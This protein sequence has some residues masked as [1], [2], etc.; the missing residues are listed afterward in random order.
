MY[1][2]GETVKYN[3]IL[4]LAKYIL[5]ICA[6]Q[7]IKLT[8]QNAPSK[9]RAKPAHIIRQQIRDRNQAKSARANNL[10]ADW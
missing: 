4:R 7:R 10:T 1:T 9:Q 6:Q 2:Q 5:K 8:N 3:K